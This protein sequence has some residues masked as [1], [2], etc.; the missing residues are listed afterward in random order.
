MSQDLDLEDDLD[1]RDSDSFVGKF[2]LLRDSI[3]SVNTIWPVGYAGVVRAKVGSKHHMIES[4]KGKHKKH[5]VSN[6]FFVTS[7]ALI[8]D[9]FEELHEANERFLQRNITTIS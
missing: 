3:W 4:C 5:V 7:R 1:V 8:F 6:E 2:F 9:T